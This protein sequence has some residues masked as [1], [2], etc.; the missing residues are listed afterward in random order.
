[1]DNLINYIIQIIPLFI[2]LSVFSSIMGQYVS[3]GQAAAMLGVC[4]KTLR[5]WEAS[6]KFLPRF[7]TDGGHRRYKRGDIISFLNNIRKNSDLDSIFPR[8]AIYARVSGSKQKTSGDLA[9]QIETLTQYCTEKR[10]ELTK[11]YEDVGSGLNDGRKGLIKM[12]EDASRGL[13]E[14]VVVNYNDR[15]AR[16]GIRVIEKFLSTWDIIVEVKNPVIIDASDPHARLITDLTAILYS[17][18][19]KL[20]RSRRGGKK[21]AKKEA[22]KLIQAVE[23]SAASLDLFSE[24]D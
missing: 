4:A 7:R 20:Y 16:F 22:E 17:F 15:L 12:L 10:Y 8:A 14:V 3:I 9:R 19:G 11:I 2:N 13:F 21:K 18:M 1:M 5:R 24:L 6:K 23:N